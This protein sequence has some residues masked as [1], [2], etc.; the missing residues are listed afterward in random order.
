MQR[1]CSEQRWPTVALRIYYQQLSARI[2]SHI[3]S[4]WRKRR[5]CLPRCHPPAPHSAQ[6]GPPSGVSVRAGLLTRRL[7]YTPRVRGRCRCRRSATALHAHASPACL[8]APTAPQYTRDTA[9]PPSSWSGL[10]GVGRRRPAGR[11]WRTQ[12]GGCRP[13]PP[14]PTP[15]WWWRGP[16]A[17]YAVQLNLGNVCAVGGA[18]RAP[19]AGSGPGG[20][21]HVSDRVGRHRCAA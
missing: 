15:Q 12:R 9:R 21:A 18:R 20:R 7:W 17:V 8:A 3:L 2:C 6:A 16:R 10:G 5:R 4:A 14:T 11:A 1:D 13:P 19:G